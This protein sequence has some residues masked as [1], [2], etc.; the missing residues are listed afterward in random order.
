[1]N[2]LANV[3][4]SIEGVNN[5]NPLIS[6]VLEVLTGPHGW[7]GAVIL[8]GLA[9]RTLLVADPGKFLDLL[10]RGE[11]KRIGYLDRYVEKPG[12]PGN[13]VHHALIDVRD[14]H[15]FKCATGIY[16]ESKRRSALLRLHRETSPAISWKFIRRANQH[17]EIDRN[18]N[19]S[20]SEKLFWSKVSI[21]YNY[22]VGAV[23][24]CVGLIFSAL[25][26]S[27]LLEAPKASIMFLG[28]AL[29]GFLV[30]AF[31]LA[32]NLPWI[33]AERLRAELKNQEV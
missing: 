15:Y 8:V 31:S 19:V 23:F 6:A 29:L 4:D 32:Q 18:G 16:A 3:T 24:L 2:G 27:T 12:V 9:L 17:I 13:D 33:S 5:L 25:F 11:K 30:S 21:W 7:I 20:I 1:M 28:V 10:E 14:A 26:L 22:C